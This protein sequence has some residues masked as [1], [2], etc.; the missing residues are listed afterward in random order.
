MKA[1]W[2]SSLESG[3]KTI[4]SQHRELFDHINTFFDS[5]SSEF[6]HEITVRTMNFL[7]KYVQYHFTTEEEF[8][9]AKCYP[10]FKIHLSAHRKIVDEIMRCYKQLI[11]DGHTEN[12]LKDLETLL[13]Q[14]LVEHIM[15]YDMKLA[16]FLKQFEES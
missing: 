12:V 1:V 14:W 13:Q 4:D 9:K 6:G 10:D 15:G 8:M 16:Q 2:T 7:V 5:V 11:S 3:N